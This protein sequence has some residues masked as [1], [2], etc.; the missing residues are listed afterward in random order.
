MRAVTGSSIL[1]TSQNVMNYTL[2]VVV[3]VLFSEL[4]GNCA[5]H[6]V[7]CEPKEGRISV[8]RCIADAC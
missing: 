5:V 3:G 2:G 1:S 8:G 6:H 4:E 7:T